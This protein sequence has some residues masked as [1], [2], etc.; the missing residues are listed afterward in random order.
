[1][2]HRIEM[3]KSNHSKLRIRIQFN[4]LCVPRST[5]Y[6]E[7]VPEKPENVKMMNIMD[8]HLFGHPTKGV[9]SMVEY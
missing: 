8:K 4:L 9:G 5:L 1:M 6:Y 2:K 3:V 7:P